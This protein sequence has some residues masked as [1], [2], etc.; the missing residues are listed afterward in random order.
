M[1]GDHLEWQLSVEPGPEEQEASILLNLRP[2]Q[3]PKKALRGVLEYNELAWLSPA[4]KSSDWILDLDELR[5]IFPDYFAMPWFTGKA[6]V[7]P[8]YPT[9]S[10]VGMPRCVLRGLGVKRGPSESP[11]K[12]T[13]DGPRAAYPHPS[14]PGRGD[15]RPFLPP[16]RYL[17]A[18][19]PRRANPR[20]A[21]EALGLRGPYPCALPAVAGHRERALLPARRAKVLLAPVPGRGGNAPLLFAPPGEEAQALLGTLA[22]RGPARVGRRSRVP[23]R[24]LAASRSLAPASSRAVGGGFCGGGMGKVGLVRPLRGEAALVVCYQPRAPR[25]RVDLRKRGRRALGGRA[26]VG[27]RTRGGRSGEEALWGFGL[28]RRDTR[29][30]AGRVRGA[31]GYREGRQAPADPPAGGGVLRGPQVR[32]RDG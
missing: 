17:H 1:A 9:L 6:R 28:P 4:P 30:G 22:P 13:S 11:A 20:V 23:H 31:A 14:V 5:R 3:D 25:L 7:Q 27:S 26:P 12:G 8:S 15:H 10:L 21:Q 2:A 32:L 18:A 19:Q 29:R 16:R 24:R